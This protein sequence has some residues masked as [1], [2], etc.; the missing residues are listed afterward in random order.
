MRA[1]SFRARRR[2]PS[3]SA[4]ILG[5]VFLVVLGMAA[6]WFGMRFRRPDLSPFPR[7]LLAVTV[8]PVGNGEATWIRTPTGRF[9]VI[10]TGTPGAESR[11]IASLQAAGCQSIDLLILP[12][13]YA[14][15]LGGATRLADTFPIRA[16][17]DNGWPRVNQRQEDTRRVLA[18]K[19][20][21][22]VPVRDGDI[23]WLDA[24][25]VR[26]LAPGTDLVRRSP[27]AGNNSLVIQLRYGQT[28]FLWAGG[29]EQAGEAALLARGPNRLRS[30][31]LHAAR[32]GNP[33]S[34]T[35]E[36]LEAVGAN[37]V[38]L[39]VGKNLPGTP[40][41]GV[42]DRIRAT[43]A[44]LLRTDSVKEPQLF[45]SDGQVVWQVRL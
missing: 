6:I 9:I 31:W 19:G 2:R 15:C 5:I 27:A 34:S 14:D 37:F 26:I 20:S 38:V 11:L 43:G 3:R 33:G 32:H 40:D 44:S 17:I 35:P 45:L 39:G 25:A 41:P 13:P 4:P 29:I 7:N 24:V 18:S 8:V 10:G 23:R 42:V 28:S 1:E 36:F 12:Y 22:V 16:A 30:Q 21:P